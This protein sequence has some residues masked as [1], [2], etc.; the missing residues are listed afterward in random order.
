ML[1]FNN[2]NTR[3][4]VDCWVRAL[5]WRKEKKYLRLWGN[6]QRDYLTSFT[7]K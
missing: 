4:I 6:L 2:K 5:K 7:K 1:K 3:T